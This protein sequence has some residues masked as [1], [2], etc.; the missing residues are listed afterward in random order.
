MATDLARTA[1]A[2][3]NSPHCRI[4][5]HTPER[6]RLGF[7]GGGVI[8]L[9]RQRWVGV[10]ERDERLGSVALDQSD[11]EP[12]VLHTAADFA[13]YPAISADGQQLAWVE[14]QQPAMPW[15]ASELHGASIDAQGHLG[16]TARWRAA[17]PA[18]RRVFPCFNPLA[19]RRNLGGSGGFERVGGI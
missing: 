16:T 19:A 7:L 3:G 15:D 11:Q 14:W 10:L 13:G 6:T 5:T 4:S 9:Q 12:R 18:Q 1:D 8:D 2:E 17:T